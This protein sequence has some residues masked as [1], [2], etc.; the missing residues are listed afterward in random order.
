MTTM[1]TCPIMLSLEGRDEGT[2][3]LLRVIQFQNPKWIP[4]RIG[5]LGSTWKKYRE[6]LEEIVLRHP[7]VFP[8]YER[9]SKDFDELVGAPNR[10]L[11]TL[12]D[13]WDCRWENIEEG[14]AGQVLG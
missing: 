14:M 7:Q 10:A 2:E 4:C 11:G 3:N 5:I 6:D 1:P 9:G 13:A 8:G 12:V